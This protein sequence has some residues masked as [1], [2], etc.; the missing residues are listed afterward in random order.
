MTVAIKFGSNPVSSAHRLIQNPQC[1]ISGVNMGEM[2]DSVGEWPG[3]VWFNASFPSSK[4]RIRTDT[5]GSK[6]PDKQPLPGSYSVAAV[7]G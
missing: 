6:N 1:W 4:M 5:G 2:D 3:V 7:C